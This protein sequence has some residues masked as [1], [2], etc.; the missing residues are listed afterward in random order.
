MT[1]LTVYF[2]LSP[3]STSSTPTS[4]Q[5]FQMVSNRIKSKPL[6]LPNLALPNSSLSRR[7]SLKKNRTFFERFN[8]ISSPTT[9]K[10]PISQQPDPLN[11]SNESQSRLRRR[12]T[13]RRSLRQSV[14][15]KG[16][17]NDDGTRSVF[18]SP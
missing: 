3:T 1:T 15:N 8:D 18:L 11:S 7:M 10:T 2:A 17:D 14:Q 13:F 12:F 9:A 4:I 5:P 6:L 16:G